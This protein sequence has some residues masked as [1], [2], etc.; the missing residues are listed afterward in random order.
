ME[1]DPKDYDIVKL[2][3]NLKK[4]EGQYPSDLLISRRQGYVQR[5]AEIGVGLGVSAAIKNTVKA[6]G[7]S[8][9]GASTVIGGVLE[10]VLLVAI[11]A[12]T[13]A[14][15]YFYR[16]QIADVVQSY[17][18]NPQVQEVSPPANDS[19]P[20]FEPVITELPEITE[21]PMP[22]PTTSGTPTPVLTIV[23]N[24]SPA[25]NQANATPD[26]KG[27]N[28]NHFGQTKEPGNN[29]GGNDKGNDK[30]KDK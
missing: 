24:G 19:D 1:I 4:A 15:A 25:D 12:E 14:A 11:V 29:N 16:D 26:P 28:G 3:T 6:G 8:G 18:S 17:I 5:V 27:N 23:V 20:I 7:K 21:T 2:L 10:A 22:T 30:G 13:S 9:G